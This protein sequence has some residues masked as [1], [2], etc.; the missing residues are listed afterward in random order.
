MELGLFSWHT[1]KITGNIEAYLLY[2]ST[3]AIKINR[4]E[5]AK[6]QISKPRV[7]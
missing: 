7:S 3:Q 6:W 4:E 2:K 1:F 5:E